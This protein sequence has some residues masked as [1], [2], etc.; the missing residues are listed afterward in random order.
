MQITKVVKNHSFSGLVAVLLVA[1]I[2]V[3]V[4]KP[5]SNLEQRVTDLE[6]KVAL[7][8]EALSG[9]DTIDTSD[10]S[11]QDVENWRQLREGMSQNRV[12]E[13]LGRPTRID[14]GTF[15]TWY[16]SERGAH[17]IVYFQRGRVIRWSEPR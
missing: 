2:G 7:I 6:N 8:E 14:G 16:Y 1:M 15:A 11:W 13:L 3:F 17:S 4:N 5:D 10:N 9:T 12:Q